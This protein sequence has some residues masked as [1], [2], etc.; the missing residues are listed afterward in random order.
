MRKCFQLMITIARRAGVEAR[1]VDALQACNGIA[2]RIGLR[3]TPW[4]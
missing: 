2:P 4:R 3:L 1:S